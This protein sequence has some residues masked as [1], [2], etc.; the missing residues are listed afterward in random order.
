A[1][2]AAPLLTTPCSNIPLQASDGARGQA[3]LFLCS[4][5]SGLMSSSWGV[6]WRRISCSTWPDTRNV[7]LRSCQV[8]VCERVCVCVC[9]CRY[10]SGFSESSPYPLSGQDIAVK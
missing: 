3:V 9:G 8:S 5:H 10:V 6:E 1:L 7:L 4:R 2:A